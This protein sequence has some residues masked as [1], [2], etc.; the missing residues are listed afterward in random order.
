MSAH[1]KSPKGGTLAAEGVASPNARY[2]RSPLQFRVYA[3][4]RQF[5]EQCSCSVS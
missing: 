1:L 4:H 5:N 2:N 3:E